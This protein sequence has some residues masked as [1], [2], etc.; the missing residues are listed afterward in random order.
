[1][2]DMP[3]YPQSLCLS[4]VPS[5]ASTSRGGRA[6]RWPRPTRS[7]PALTPNTQHPTPDPEHPTPNT[8]HRTPDTEPRTPNPNR[9]TRCPPLAQSS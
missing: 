1:M 4:G 2:G 7:T 8:E 5:S 9:L 6:S 3:R